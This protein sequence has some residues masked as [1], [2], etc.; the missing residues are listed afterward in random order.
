MKLSE[1]IL[2]VV[3]QHQGNIILRSDVAKLGSSSQVS[4]V[5]RRLQ[6]DEVLVRIGLGVYAKTRTS[7]VTGATIPA[8]SLE[9]LAGEVLQRLGIAVTAGRAARD[10]NAGATTQMPGMLVANTGRRRIS[11]KLTVGGRT[12]KYEN[13]YGVSR[14]G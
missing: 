10:Y 2:Q 5:L 3:L 7:T 11:R 6:A 8:G 14:D 12:L 1:Q 9:T 13:D 4:A